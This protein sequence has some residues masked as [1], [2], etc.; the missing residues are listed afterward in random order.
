MT[1]PDIA[2]LKADGWQDIGH[3]ED[4]ALMVKDESYSLTDLAEMKAKKWGTATWSHTVEVGGISGV[5][6]SESYHNAPRIPQPHECPHCY[7]QTHPGPLTERQARMYDNNHFDASYDPAADDSPV[8]CI[9][10]DYEG[11][12]PAGVLQRHNDGLVKWVTY[13]S[14]YDSYSYGSVY[15]SLYANYMK[16]YAKKLDQ[17]WSKLLNG[18]VQPLQVSTW[19]IDEPYYYIAGGSP[20][21]PVAPEKKCTEDDKLPIKFN[22]WDNWR[23]WEK[24]EPWYPIEPALD[25][26]WEQWHSSFPKPESPGYDFTAFNKSGTYPKGKK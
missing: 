17:E 9:G 14:S 16:D 24:P 11:P 1:F 8:V 4:G 6:F 23:P 25:I 26:K 13:G 18:W 3:I 22:D 5:T 21:L 2:E 19:L 10:A 7:R 15:Q 12:M 20:Y